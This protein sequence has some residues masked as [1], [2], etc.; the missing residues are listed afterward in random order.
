MYAHAQFR[1]H[2]K[3][4]ADRAVKRAYAALGAAERPSFDELLLAV[5]TRSAIPVGPTVIEPLRNLAR[6]ASS[7]VRPLREWSGDGGAMYAVIDSLAQHLLARHRVPRFL[8]SVW[9]H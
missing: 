7:R 2:A 8:T 4:E 9:Y 5:R 1:R 3:L 6:F